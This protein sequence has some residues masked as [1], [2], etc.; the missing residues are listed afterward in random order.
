[1][2]YRAYFFVSMIAV[3]FSFSAQA[4][5][6][7]PADAENLTTILRNVTGLQDIQYERVA[8]RWKVLHP[9][10]CTYRHRN[11]Q[12][13]SFAWFKAAKVADILLKYR[14]TVVVA[15]GLEEV[16]ISN[17]ECGASLCTFE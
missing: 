10:I 5:E 6:L 2:P 7:E 1:M 13:D 16:S 4:D 9:S 8:C 12:R 11:G 14:G 15:G 3:L 17:L